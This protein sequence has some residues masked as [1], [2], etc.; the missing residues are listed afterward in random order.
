M[1]A[2]AH[3][4]NETV[5][6]TRF[7]LK[8]RHGGSAVLLQSDFLHTG[9]IMCGFQHLTVY[10]EKK[11]IKVICTYGNVEFFSKEPQILQVMKRRLRICSQHLALYSLSI[12]CV[13]IC[14]CLSFPSSYTFDKSFYSLLFHTL[15]N[16][17]ALKSQSNY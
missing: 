4:T 11:G 16:I 3:P 13:S 17:T 6:T 14:I 15:F 9:V 12:L 8:K 7:L 1:R 5:S 2:S 10:T